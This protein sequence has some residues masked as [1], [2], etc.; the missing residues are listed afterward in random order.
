[1]VMSGNIAGQV[2]YGTVHGDGILTPSVGTPFLRIP[3][4]GIDR[5]FGPYLCP[6]GIDAHLAQ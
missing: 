6:F 2:V 5:H 1:M 4:G 3:D